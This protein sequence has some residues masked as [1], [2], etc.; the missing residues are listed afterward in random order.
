MASNVLVTRKPPPAA[1]LVGLGVA[2]IFPLLTNLVVTHVL[3][4]TLSGAL[5]AAGLVIHWATFALLL[6][7]VLRWERE[8]LQSI[9]WDSPRWSTVL[10]GIVAGLIIAIVSGLVDPLLRLRAD[11][12]FLAFLQ[13]MPLMVRV[14]LVITAGVYEE[15]L[16]RGYAIERLSKYFGGK[17][18]AAAITL[19]LFTYAHASAVGAAQLAPIM[20]VAGLVTVLY[21]WRRDL[22]LNMVAHVTIDA[23]GRLG[24]PPF[25]RR[26]PGFG[27]RPVAQPRVHRLAA[28]ETG[29][30]IRE[31][32]ATG[33]RL[34]ERKIQLQL[35]DD[36]GGR[37]YEV[38]PTLTERAQCLED[39]IPGH[40]PSR[41]IEDPRHVT[42]E[43]RHH[44]RTEVADVD[45]LKADRV[46]HEGR[47]RY[48]LLRCA[49]PSR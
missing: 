24:V 6:V 38:H 28:I 34:H 40:G 48:P 37:P 27:Q 44:P 19:A 36:R 47:P 7:I 42:L 32:A 23:L 3:G 12:H 5:I 17:W 25:Q 16:Y 30:L 41:S 18:V 45:G 43:Q 26:P 8:P 46:G 14:A 21:L 31:E 35:L 13:S 4:L 9:G 29:A 10:F 20:I 33:R 11:T 1:T 39:P 49:P 22:L 2:L 15:T